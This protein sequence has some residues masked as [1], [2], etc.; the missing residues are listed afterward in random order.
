MRKHY[1][2]GR[3]FETM[4]VNGRCEATE[5]NYFLMIKSGRFKYKPR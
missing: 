4:K 3:C 1:F 2:L 5:F